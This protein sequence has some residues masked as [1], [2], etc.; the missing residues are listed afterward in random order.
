MILDMWMGF[1]QTSDWTGVS[2]DQL[3]PDV[4]ILTGNTIQSE[5]SWSGRVYYL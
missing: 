5:G 3:S 1:W 4:W 2:T